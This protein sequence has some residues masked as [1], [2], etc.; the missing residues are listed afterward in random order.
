M[1]KFRISITRPDGAAVTLYPGSQGERDFVKSVV[2]VVTSKRDLAKEIAEVAM[3]K[4][5]GFLKTE[6]H[7]RRDLDAA[8]K[9]ILPKFQQDLLDSINEVIYSLK[10]EVKP[11]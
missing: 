5:I 4:G 6:K 8:L 10:A 9:E 7:V 2:D 3:S 11:H 1:S